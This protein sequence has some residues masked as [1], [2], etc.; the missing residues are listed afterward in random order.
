MGVLRAEGALLTKIWNIFNEF[1]ILLF[2]NAI[3]LLE[4]ILSI[5]YSKFYLQKMACLIIKRQFSL[6]TYN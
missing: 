5:K 1:L 6:K 3:I 2:Q 4:G